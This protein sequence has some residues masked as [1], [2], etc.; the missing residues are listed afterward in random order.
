[1]YQRFSFTPNPNLV[2]NSL[3][4]GIQNGSRLVDLAN[5]RRTRSNLQNI[6]DLARKGLVSE[7]DFNNLGASLIAN[8][9]VGQGMNAINTPYDRN[10]ADIARQDKLGQQE[11]MNNFRQSQQDSLN[12][13]RAR[14]LAQ[15]ADQFNRS[16]AL[17]RQRFQFDQQ[18]ANTPKIPTG[19]T[20][21]DPADPSAGI[22][23]LPGLPQEAPQPR[24][25]AAKIEADREAG[26]I[27]DATAD[28]MLAN[29]TA[30]KNGIT[31]NKDGTVQIGG[32]GKAPT[33]GQSK[34]NIYA[35]RG[36]KANII[37]DTLEY[38]GTN[39]LANITSRTPLVGNFSVSPAYRQYDQAKRDFINAVLRQ[40]SGAVISPA[41]FENAEKQY[42]PQPGDDVLT[43][44][45][46]RR[47]RRTAMDAIRQAAGPFSGE[48]AAQQADS[49]QDPLGLR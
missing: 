9:Q 6:A 39:F 42:F 20:F 36:E 4:G 18:S 46:K 31:I 49:A 47:N 48:N 10:Q 37:L 32:S 24:T 12:S 34:A 15:Q 38:E 44:N 2:N 41:E 21:N 13:H 45:Q 30:P 27:D 17:A 26:L 35:T 23:P 1:M 22:S 33:E 40:E 7:E 29:A 25:L 11:F 28:R 19:Y 43:V 14:S 16:N 5:Q 3:G 8:G